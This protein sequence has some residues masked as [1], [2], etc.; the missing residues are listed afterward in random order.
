MNDYGSPVVAPKLNALKSWHQPISRQTCVRTTDLIL[1]SE[2]F[3]WL[4]VVCVMEVR[5]CKMELHWMNNGKL[6]WEKYAREI[7]W[8]R[9]VRKKIVY[10]KNEIR[11]H[12]IYK[13]MY[14]R[15]APQTIDE[16]AKASQNAF[17]QHAR[18]KSIQWSTTMVW[19]LAHV[20]YR[21][22]RNSQDGM[23]WKTLCRNR[24]LRFQYMKQKLSFNFTV[25]C[26]LPPSQQTVRNILAT[27]YL[28]V[29]FMT[30]V[31]REQS[32]AFNINEFLIFITFE[33]ENALKIACL[34]KLH[35]SNSRNLFYCARSTFPTIFRRK[36]NSKIVKHF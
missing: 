23:E 17:S 2:R 33:M 18:I 13:Y 27:L 16:G 10:L 6:R 28:G 15:N 22:K 5:V 12:N 32:I 30:L 36:W 21:G 26:H 20:V 1:F 7:N 8:Q 9:S 14:S 31:K 4:T 29:L 3:F 35:W 34:M 19:N 11:A 24:I 25:S